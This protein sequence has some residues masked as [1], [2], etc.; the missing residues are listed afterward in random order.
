MTEVVKERNPTQ[1]LKEAGVERQSPLTPLI[2]GG[3]APRP[4]RG[5]FRPT[6]KRR[7][8]LLKQLKTDVIISGGHND[9]PYLTA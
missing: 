3:Q 5:G 8:P 2:E 9:L 1:T 4:F 6:S 7:P